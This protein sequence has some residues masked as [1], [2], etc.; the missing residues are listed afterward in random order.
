MNLYRVD[1]EVYSLLDWIGDIGGLM[2]GLLLIF[3]VLL[4]AI[5]FNKFDHYMIES[6]Y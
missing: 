2:E 4:A 5:Q 3:G 6:L 1:R